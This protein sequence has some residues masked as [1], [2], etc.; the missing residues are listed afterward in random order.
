MSFHSVL[1][2]EAGPDSKAALSC[3]VRGAERSRLIL[4]NLKDQF[5]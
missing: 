1:G 3:V 4:T 5:S 2:G